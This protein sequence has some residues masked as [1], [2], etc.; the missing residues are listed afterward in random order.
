MRQDRDTRRSADMFTR[1]SEVLPGGVGSSARSVRAGWVPYPPFVASGAGSHVTDVDG[2]EYVDYLMGLGPL[3]FGHR[4]SEVTAAVV[5][6]VQ[7]LGTVLASYVVQPWIER[8]NGH[9]GSMPGT[10]IQVFS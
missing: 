8:L 1:A 3:I 4:P 5:R 2:T 6:A 7:E 10:E 9:R